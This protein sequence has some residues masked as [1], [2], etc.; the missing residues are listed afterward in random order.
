VL[1]CPT[2]SRFLIRF[3]GEAPRTSGTRELQPIGFGA[4]PSRDQK[5]GVI[6][7]YSYCSLSAAE[8]RSDT[9]HSTR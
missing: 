7:P 9:P 3:A 4:G 6:R 1:P 5:L 2:C 8:R